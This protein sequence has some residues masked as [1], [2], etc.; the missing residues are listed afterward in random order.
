MSN[1]RLGRRSRR[2][3]K[4]VNQRLVEVVERAIIIT[5]QDFAVIEGVR[6]LKRQRYLYQNGF[7]WTMNSKH[8]VG[9]AVDLA[10]WV[11]VDGKGK[12]DWD[13][14]H[15]FSAIKDAMFKAAEQLNVAIRWGGDWNQNGSHLDEIKR[16]VYD[17]AH[18]ELM[19]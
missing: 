9:R 11:I 15:K 12:I 13:D 19:D 14:L 5:E 2:R 4:G 18:F 6:G 17:G 8:L 7:S 3:L 1:Y 16:G 10:P